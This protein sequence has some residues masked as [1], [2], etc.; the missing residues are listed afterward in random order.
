[1]TRTLYLNG[2]WLPESEAKVSVFDRGF[3]MADGIYE[4]TCVLDGKLVD[5]AGHAARLQ[6]SAQELGLT[7][8]LTE[9]EL[10]AVHREIVAR[11]ALDQG[12]IYLQLTRGV[13]ERD[14]VY[15]PAG[16]PPT[17]VMFTQAKNVLENAAAEAGIRVALLPDLRWGRRDIKTV[18]L[19]YPCMAKMEARARGADDAWLVEDGFV[20]EAS[21]AT[22]H[23]VT[24]EGVLV[25]RDLSHAL[26]PGIT[27]ASVLELAAAHGVRVEERAFTPDEARA[28]R[29]AFITSATNFVVPVVAIDGATVG[30]GKPGALTRDLRRFYIETRR[31]SAI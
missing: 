31:A 4:V 18:Q 21:A 17:L 25:T 28:A 3:L 14:F 9:A 5:Y 30:D 26:L 24:A 15:P 7:L 29:E 10:L 12:M 23:I 22:S 8:P 1:M 16:T 6:R 20:T 2:A 19:L 13:A 27:R 11:N